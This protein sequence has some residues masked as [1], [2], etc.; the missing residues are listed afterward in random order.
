ML[1]FCK[2]SLCINRVMTNLNAGNLRCVV[3][4]E[5]VGIVVVDVVVA[6][7]DIVCVKFEFRISRGL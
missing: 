5:V 2:V 6:V 4:V 7:I 3:D 1:A